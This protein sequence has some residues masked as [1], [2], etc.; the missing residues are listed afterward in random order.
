VLRDGGAVDADI[1]LLHEG[2]V[3]HMQ[4]TRQIRAEHAWDAA[5]HCWRPVLD[6]WGGC[7]IPNVIVAGDAG[8][9]G[10]ARVAEA[11]GRLAA[12]QAAHLLGRL[13]ERE[14][15]RRAAAPRSERRRHLAI[16]PLLDALFPPS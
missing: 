12:L 7:S 4:I 8:G 3:P 6:G 1:V 2:V 11:A 15:N 9:I 14:R 10:G 13:S 16:R 5:Q